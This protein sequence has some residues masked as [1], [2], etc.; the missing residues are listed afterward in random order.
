MKTA[1]PKDIYMLWQTIICEIGG[2]A[3]LECFSALFC[4]FVVSA[5]AAHV[6]HFNALLARGVE[7]VVG[8]ADV[9]TLPVAIFLGVEFPNVWAQVGKGFELTGETFHLHGRNVAV[10]LEVFENVGAHQLNIEVLPSLGKILIS[11]LFE[12]LAHVAPEFAGAN[13][14]HGWLNL[15]LW[16]VCLHPQIEAHALHGKVHIGIPLFFGVVAAEEVLVEVGINRTALQIVCVF[17]LL[18]VIVAVDHVEQT[19]LARWVE[20]T[21]NVV[22]G[23]PE[24]GTLFEG[25]HEAAVVL[26]VHLHG[27]GDVVVEKRCRHTFVHVVNLQDLRELVYTVQPVRIAGEVAGT[28]ALMFHFS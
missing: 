16:I 6:E 15:Y 2:A 17:A 21:G 25:Y 14:L 28:S 7:R 9:A 22:G 3:R 4:Q 19:A 1:P 27:T 20:V 26:G 8:I 23:E 12:V 10:T 5:N 18:V 24:F 11:P 13:V